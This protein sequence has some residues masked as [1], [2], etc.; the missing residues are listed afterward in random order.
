[1]TRKRITHEEIGNEERRNVTLRKRTEGLVKKANELSTLCGVEAAIVIHNKGGQNN[2]VLWPSPIIFA[3]R[4][5]KF[6][7]FGDEERARRGVTHER[8]MKQMVEGEREEIAKLK[9][10]IQLKETQQLMAKSVQNNN[11]FHGIHLHQLNHMSSFA[12]HI[13]KKL[14]AKDNHLIN[15]IALPLPH[16]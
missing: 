2:A 11:S 13:L 9:K 4:L 7:D 10:T 8:L 3:E 15:A 14:V 12:D 1:M 5:Q 16:Q 6:L